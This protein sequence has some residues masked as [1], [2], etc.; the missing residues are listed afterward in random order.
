MVNVLQRDC[1]FSC[2]WCFFHLSYYIFVVS[3]LFS[4]IRCARVEKF[5]SE[6]ARHKVDKGKKNTEKN[7]FFS[8]VVVCCWLLATTNMKSEIYNF[9]NF[10][11]TVE[12]TSWQRKWEERESFYAFVLYVFLFWGKGSI[13][14][15]HPTNKLFRVYIFHFFS[16]LFKIG[17]IKAKL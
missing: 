15:K 8:I 4:F 16:L 13:F 11:T 1:A 3:K 14:L 7:R 2:W 17:S 6:T 10:Q 12:T 9:I 5:S